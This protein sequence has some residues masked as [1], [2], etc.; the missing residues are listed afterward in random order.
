MA[1]A[2]VGVSGNTLVVVNKA[3]DGIRKLATVAPNYTTFT[4]AAD[5]SLK[6]TG[7]KVDAPPGNSP[8]Q[9]L[10]ATGGKVVVSTE[11]GGP[12]RA[13]TLGGDGKLTQGP[14]SPVTIPASAYPENFD[15]KLEWALG[16]G[17]H[18]T[19]KIVYGQLATIHQMGIFTY[20]DAA[21]LTFVKGVQNNGGDLPCWTLINKQGTR[22]YTDNAGNN[23]MTVYD[24]TDPMNPKQLQLLKLKGNG[25]PWD[26][27]FSPDEKYV[28]MVDPRARDNVKPGEGQAVH[29]LV[30]GPDGKLSETTEPAPIPVDLNVNPI[31]MAVAPNG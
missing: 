9:A 16:L 8:T 27:R 2:S 29:S 23:T 20:D 24:I 15:P 31:G 28:F 21:N 10:I 7:S 12:L 4:I 25:N 11:E 17:V 30:V 6:P 19:Q 14:N 5:G 1:P 3:Q 18:P 22:L 26:V 13:F